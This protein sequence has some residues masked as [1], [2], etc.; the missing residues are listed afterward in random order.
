MYRSVMAIMYFFLR[1]YQEAVSKRYPPVLTLKTKVVPRLV[2]EGCFDE[3]IRRMLQAASQSD[4]LSEV[5]SDPEMGRLVPVPINSDLVA[6]RDT[7]WRFTA[8]KAYKRPSNVDHGSVGHRLDA[9]DG[10][11]RVEN[12]E[13]GPHQES[14]CSDAQSRGRCGALHEDEREP[15][16]DQWQCY[17]DHEPIWPW[18]AVYRLGHL[19]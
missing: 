7:K 10:G 16:D 19:G 2:L 14:G 8:F 13:D 3:T 15:S 17:D 11:L 18:T 4:V 12:G 1:K 6:T 5:L 9:F